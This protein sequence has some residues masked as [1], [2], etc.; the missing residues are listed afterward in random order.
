MRAALRAAGYHAPTPIQAGTIAA[1][2]AGRDVIGAAQTGTGKT[3]AFLVP[4]I[5]RLR[6]MRQHDNRGAALIL[7]PTRE[8][9]EQIHSWTQRLGADLRAALVVGGVAYGPQLAALRGRPAVVI[10]TPGRLVDHIERGSVPLRDVR[11]LVLDEADRML[12]MGFKPQLDRIMGGLPAPRQTLLFSATMAAD[13]GTLARLHLHDPVRV[14]VGRQAVP[15]TRTVQDVY[16]VEQ[17][18]K[19]PLLLSLIARNRGNV[20]VFTRTKHRT[21]RVARTVR[22]AGHA[23]QRIHADRSQSQRREA[24]EGFRSGRYR[25]LIATDIAARGIDVAGIGRVINYDLPH[26]VEDYVH[27]VGRTARAE[28]HGH[29]TSFATPEERGQLHAIER[30]LGSALPRQSHDVSRLAS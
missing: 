19:M 30:H 29:A 21:D 4:A 2:L 17:Q 24:L 1:A 8:L 3:A 26:T 6:A 7:A 22:Q 5:E 28:A 13:I 12:D 20:L 16:L 10:A 14:A 18:S 15:P 23:V 25:I 27:R 11:I 9:A